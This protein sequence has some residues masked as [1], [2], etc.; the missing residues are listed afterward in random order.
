MG[1]A[2][3]WVGDPQALLVARAWRSTLRTFAEQIDVGERDQAAGLLGRDGQR[4]RGVWRRARRCAR[5]GG[6]WDRPRG[7]ATTTDHGT[8]HERD[9]QRGSG[10]QRDCHGP[11]PLVVAGD[12]AA[13][14]A[15]KPAGALRRALRRGQS[16]TQ[17]CLGTANLVGVE[18]GGEH[19]C[20]VVVH[21]I[22]S[23]AGA[24][25]VV[26]ATRIARVARWRR[27]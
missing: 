16:A 10:Q 6:R 13:A 9:D 22:D 20:V 8:S 2:A 21:R 15:D 25:G 23:A 3:I 11:S 5:R 1:I 24:A 12:R 27:E 26:S 7:D 17:G 14:E 4:R 18:P 19:A